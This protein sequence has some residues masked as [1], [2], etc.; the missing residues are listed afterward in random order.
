MTRSVKSRTTGSG[1]GLNHHYMALS[2][3]TTGS[4]APLVIPSV[5]LDRLRREGTIRCRFLW[6]SLI[7]RCLMVIHFTG[8]SMIGK[9]RH[10]LS[11]DHS[12]CLVR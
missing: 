4:D 10:V 9:K 6:N 7:L 2:S 8:E 11:Y 12:V 3:L 1:C 5:L